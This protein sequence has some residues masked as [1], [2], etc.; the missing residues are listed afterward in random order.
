MPCNINI[1]V[2]IL[3]YTAFRINLPQVNALVMSVFSTAHI[4]MI[5]DDLPYMLSWHIFL[6]S[7]YE[8]KLPLLR[9]P[10]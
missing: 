4:A 9:K 8:A 5:P 3:N 10:L 1:F 7:V 2:E 6:L